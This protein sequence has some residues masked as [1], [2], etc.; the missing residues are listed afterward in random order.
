MAPDDVDYVLITPLQ[1][2]ATANIPLFR[3]ATVCISRRG[4]I[5]DFHAPRF[6]PHQPREFRIPKD[7][8]IYLVTDWWERV[9]LLEDEDE[10]LPGIRASWVGTHHR[11]SMAYFVETTSGVVAISNCFIKFRN[12]EE[13]IP[14]G[15][16]ESMEE[17]LRA[18]ERV[19][20]WADLALPLYDPEVFTRHPEGRI[21]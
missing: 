4:W 8:L 3:G 19:R 7:V 11:S 20:K 5:E 13:N 2:Y 6:P 15:V 16:Q 10:V 12:L 18:Y 17:C 9:R 1:N 21:P 14:L